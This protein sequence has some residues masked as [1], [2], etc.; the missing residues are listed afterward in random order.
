MHHRV[1]E[2]S[3]TVTAA[4]LGAMR[5]LLSEEVARA[6]L[7]LD[8]SR[9]YALRVCSS[10]FIDNAIKHA[11]GQGPGH[12]AELSIEVGFDRERSRLRIT[13]TDPS[14]VEPAM[15]SSIDD[16]DATCGRGLM[17]ADGYADD[18]GWHQRLDLQGRPTGWSV[19]FELDVEPGA[20]GQATA[21]EAEAQP[22]TVTRSPERRV[23]VVSGQAPGIAPRPNRPQRPRERT[24]AV[25]T[26]ASRCPQAPGRPASPV[27]PSTPYPRTAP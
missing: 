27:H 22:K 21:A 18:I 12:E 16:L 7:V 24:T 2:F 3:A 1:L 15:S 4:S 14:V 8:E 13:V 19:W 26:V 17:V 11:A 5:N 10:E 9:A 25:P 20:F 23:K 6:G